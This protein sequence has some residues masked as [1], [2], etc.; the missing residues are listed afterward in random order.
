[1]SADISSIHWFFLP[2]DIFPEV[3]LLNHRV[4]LFLICE[5]PS[6]LFSIMAIIS[7]HSH[8]QCIRV[9]SSF[10]LMF[11]SCLLDNRHPYKCEAIS[12]CSFDLYFLIISNIEHLHVPV[13]HY[14]SY[15]ERC[16]F[17]S[18][19]HFLNWIA[20]FFAEFYE[21]FTYFGY[22]PLVRYMICKYFL[23]FHFVVSFAMVKLFSLI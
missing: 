12:H 7:L 18:A 4:V 16:L 20:L 17:R 9:F 14:M 6:I 13:G 23:S 15:L 3:A 22:Y 19:D 1:M 2:L 11:I 10:L 8:Q 21:F 5:E